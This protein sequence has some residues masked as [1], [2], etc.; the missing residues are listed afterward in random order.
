MVY[1][2][3]RRVFKHDIFSKS[4]YDFEFLKIKCLI[5]CLVDQVFSN[6][7]LTVSFIVS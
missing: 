4:L 3:Q 1:H 6:K 7:L 5:F 2:I